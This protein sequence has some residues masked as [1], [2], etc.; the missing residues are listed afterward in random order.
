MGISDSISGM[1]NK[2]KDAVTGHADEAEKLTDAAGDKIDD[3]TEGKYKDQVDKGQNTAK[4]AMGK[5]KK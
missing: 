1:G 3:A 2:A 5:M 4:D